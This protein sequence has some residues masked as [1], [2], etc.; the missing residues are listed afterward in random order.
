MTPELRLRPA[1]DRPCREDGAYVLYWMTACRRTRWNFAL[2]RA[3]EEARAL[4]RPLV[5]LETLPSGRRWDSER[6]HRFALDGMRDNAARFRE[7]RVTYVPHVERAPGEGLACLDHLARRACLVVTDDYPCFTPAELVRDATRRLDVRLEAVDSGGILPAAATE[8][9]FPTAFAFRRFLQSVLPEHLAAM[10]ERDPLR[11][12]PPPARLDLPE[13]WKTGLEVDLARL[14]IDHRVAPT[15]KGGEREARRRMNDF[16][17]KRLDRYDEDRNHPDLDGSSGLSP[18]LAFGHLSAHEV[19]A[20]LV[21][22][23]PPRRRPTGR[24]AGWWHLPSPVES[25]LDEL[26]TWRE[27]GINYCSKRDDYDRY[28]SLPAWARATLEKHARDP[29]N[30]LYSARALEAA[31][32]HDPL[33]NAAQRQL[34]REGRLHNYM[35]MLWGK[36]ILEWTRSPREALEFMIDLNNK[37][38]LDGRD[39]NSYSGIFWVLGRYDRP[40]GPERPVFGLVRY[41]SSGSTARKLRVSKYVE[42]YGP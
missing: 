6:F 33:W 32:T 29:R 34:V 37:Y 40:W 18:Y 28:E 4:R 38:A 39:P 15:Q 14:P 10:P 30:P 9:V 25:F 36:K 24:K 27:L 21:K 19:V 11:R 13:R 35:R 8:R 26:V 17:R 22:T 2:Q 1:V 7:A 20:S 31:D 16:L 5:V 12:L 23:P 42:R 3:A 41:M